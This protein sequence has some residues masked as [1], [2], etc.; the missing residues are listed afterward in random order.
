MRALSLGLLIGVLWLQ[1]RSELPSVLTSIALLVISLSLLIAVL[2]PSLFPWRDR[3]NYKVITLMIAGCCLGVGWSAWLAHERLSQSLS[4]EVEGRDIRL[5]G[6]IEGLPDLGATGKRFRFRVEQ[7]SLMT[8]EKITVPSHVSLG[9][10]SDRS[11]D[12]PELKSGQRWQLTVRLKRPHGLSN[13]GVFD[14]EA[15]L[16][17]EGLRAT[18]S[19]QAQGHRLLDEQI[20]HPKIWIDR[21]RA[22]LREK[23]LTAL[24]NQPYAGVII[25]LVIG[26]QRAVS[27]SDWDVFNR[28]GV[29]HL[30][31]ISGLHITM[32]AGLFSLLSHWLWRHSFFTRAQLPLLCPAHKVAALA[33]L[34]A[35]FSYVALAGFG[36]PAQR[37]LLMI[38]VVT[39]SLLLHRIVTVSQILLT[40]LLVV[41]LFDPWSVLWPGFWLSF[42]AIGC[43]LG[44]ERWEWATLPVYAFFALGSLRYRPGQSTWDARGLG[45]A[46]PGRPVLATLTLASAIFFLVPRPDV[47]LW[48]PSAHFG[49]NSRSATG[50]SNEVDLTSTGTLDLD[51]E[52]AFEVDARQ[53]SGATGTLSADSRFRQIE[54]ELYRM[55]RWR[56]T[57]ESTAGRGVPMASSQ[58]PSLGV[59]QML[60]TFHLFSK[61]ITTPVVLDQQTLFLPVPLRRQGRLDAIIRSDNTYQQIVNRGQ[62]PERMPVQDE[63]TRAIRREDLLGCPGELREWSRE[64]LLK[65]ADDQTGQQ[66]Q[67]GPMKI[68]PGRPG[69]RLPLDLMGGPAGLPPSVPL[70]VVAHEEAARRLC[71]YL[72]LSG[73]YTYSLDRKRSDLTIDPG[74]DFL[75][76]VREGHCERFASG[77]ALSLRSLGIPAR[78]VKGVRGLCGPKLP[79]T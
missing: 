19:V 49:H 16:L 7:A 67:V 3:S 40:A 24:P 41:L 60:L 75:V 18:G 70:P 13:P 74:I 64:I 8:D 36:I 76:N 6:S 63:V 77:L 1:S 65:L 59:N 5:I 37:T 2:I 53:A 61:D 78:M 32:I 39:L 55:G 28:T 21:T 31:S 71:D 52:V 34:L 69:G 33:G 51:S 47:P 44:L 15:W 14:A 66:P 56:G 35:A 11:S 4:A 17:N 57:A 29:G 42:V 23:I 9:W 79:R 58:L 38:A 46:T 22:A 73:E 62:S 27:Q 50:A 48:N 68:R 72:S 25:A 20:A 45:L 26:D 43:I 12:P 10:Y 30:I 54:L